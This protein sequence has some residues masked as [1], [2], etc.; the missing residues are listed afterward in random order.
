MT[1][2]QRI[3]IRV[4]EGLMQLSVAIWI[5]NYPMVMPFA[6]DRQVGEIEGVGG[7]G[8]VG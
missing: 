6:A 3:G 8:G 5:I 7:Q 4:Q 2:V 1:Q